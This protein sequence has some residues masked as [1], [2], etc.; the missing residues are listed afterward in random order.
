MANTSH[1]NIDMPDSLRH[2]WDMW[3]EPDVA[4]V[5]GHLDRAVSDDVLFVDPLH[6]HVG[7]DALEANVCALRTDKPAYFF[8]LASELD[9][10]NDRYRYRW[11]LVKNGRVLI[12]GFVVTTLNADGMIERIDGFFGGLKEF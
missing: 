4:K 5:R 2:Y 11:D 10:H 9:G 7:R 8:A 12:E 1:E 3:N 6:N